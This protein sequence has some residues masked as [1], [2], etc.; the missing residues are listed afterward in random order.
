MAPPQRPWFRVYTETFSDPKI[1]R[2]TPAR[3]WLWISVLGAARKSSEPGVLLVSS[4]IAM[5]A[6]DIAEFAGL[7]AGEVRKGLPELERLGMI[8]QETGDRRAWVITNWDDRQYESDTS[9]PRVRKHRSNTP[10]RNG[11]RPLHGRSKDRYNGVAVTPPESESESDPPQVPHGPPPPPGERPQDTDT[12]HDQHTPT[13][14][15]RVTPLLERWLTVVDQRP[16]AQT[17][18]RHEAGPL[19]VHLLRYVDPQVVDEAIGRAAAA[20]TTPRSPRYLLAATRDWAN[21]HMPELAIPD[22]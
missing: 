7:P 19:I 5:D 10:S 13:S 8:R 14:D 1:R 16:G 9:T 20:G 22:P 6:T 21:T 3:R 15:P 4:A 17:R 2:L 11:D 12:D 18:H